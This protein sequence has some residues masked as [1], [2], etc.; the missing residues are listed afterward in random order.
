MSFW[1]LATPPKAFRFRGAAGPPVT[2]VKPDK[3][4][5]DAPLWG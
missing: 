2:A 4:R 1:A 5:G 3:L